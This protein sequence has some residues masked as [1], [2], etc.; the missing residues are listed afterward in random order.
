MQ[1]IFQYHLSSAKSG[2]LIENK[3]LLPSKDIELHLYETTTKCEG[4]QMTFSLPIFAFMMAGDKFINMEGLGR[5]KYE[6][7]SSLIV[8]SHTKL[9]IDF[10]TASPDNPTQCLAFVPDEFLVEEAKLDFYQQTDSGMDVEQDVHL[11]NGAVLQDIGIMRTIQNLIFLF[12]ENNEQRD[13]FI[14]LTTKE[15]IIRILQSK[16]RRFFLQQFNSSE[17]AMSR[18]ARYIRDN[19][20]QSLSA[21]E[22]S[23][24]AGMSR[25]KFYKQFK[26]IFGISPN[27]Y[28]IQEKIEKAKT[29][30]SFKQLQSITEIAY[31]LGY[32][33]SAYFTKQFKEVTGK[34]PSFY[35][36]KQID[37]E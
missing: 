8:P 23:Q 27:Q 16:A 9:S 31:S 34:S 19:I 22:L 5:F 33:D 36:K 2:I 4:V 25:S 26:A 3:A 32:S 15:L 6:P 29:A 12:R 28:V 37:K 17:N 35:R 10:P 24:I 7:G 20:H 13:Y 30:L 11:G 18:V 21:G 1:N 14:N